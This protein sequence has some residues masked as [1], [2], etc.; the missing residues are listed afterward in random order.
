MEEIDTIIAAAEEENPAIPD[1]EENVYSWTF[2]DGAAIKQ[3][4]RHVFLYRETV[5]PPGIHT[6]FGAG[7]LV[8]G[9]KVRVVLWHG[10]RR[11]DAFIE[12]TVHTAPVT[13]MIWKPDFAAVL[14]KKYPQWLEFF[15]KSRAESGDTPWIR[16]TKRMEP[17]HYTIELEGVVPEKVVEDFNVTLKAGDTIDNNALHTIFRCSLL[18][19]MRRS[20]STGS[21]VLIADHSKAGCEDKWIGKVFHFTGMGAIGEQGVGSRQNTTLAKSREN[22]VGLYLFEVFYEGNY[23]YIGEVELMD[24]PYRSRQLDCEKNMRD[25]LVFPLQLRSHKN[26]PLIK[27]EVPEAGGEPGRRNVR[28]LPPVTAGVPAEKPGKNGEHDAF[29]D[30]SGRETTGENAKRN[31]NGLCQLCGLP[32]PFAGHDGQP[33]LEVHHIVPLKEGGNH[34][35]GNVVALCPNCHRKMH[36]LNLQADVTKLKNRVSEGP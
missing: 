16:F 6:Y 19:P 30:L 22:G 2:E 7:D 9:R 23:V 18:G 26:P 27:P 13:R 11:F 21:L 12:K 5:I 14:Q 3:A 34:T 32:A 33:Y 1:E 29:A 31:A 15:K 10:D 4:D 24:N 25:V 36:V 35:A 28:V 17:G 8:P 20:L